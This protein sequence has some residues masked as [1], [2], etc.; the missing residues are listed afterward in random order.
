MNQQQKPDWFWHLTLNTADTRKSYRSEV[1]ADAL[2]A[3]QKMGLL[4]PE[5]HLPVG[6][7][8]H[9][10]TTTDEGG[11]VFTV[12]RDDIPLV[13]C[14][15][16]LDA[17]DDGGYWAVLEQMYLAVTDKISTESAFPEKPASPPW[18][19]VMLLGLGYAPEAA[20]W[21]GDFECCMAWLLIDRFYERSD[22]TSG[23]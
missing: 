5:V 6:H 14:L 1:G 23:E 8:Y 19:A 16:A 4:E 2:E 9:L 22:E 13:H 15:L 18:L 11:A 20:D 12:F 21:L 17:N 3:M 10:K 7:G